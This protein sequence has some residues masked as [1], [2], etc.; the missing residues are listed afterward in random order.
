MY[1]RTGYSRGIITNLSDAPNILN[2]QTGETVF[3]LENNRVL[4]Y[5]G[6]LWMCDDFIKMTNNS[7][8]ACIACDLMGIATSGTL[9]AIKTTGTT[10]RTIGPAIYGAANGAFVA[11]AFKGIYKIKI[12]NVSSGPAN[13]IGWKVVASS[14]GNAGAGINNTAVVAGFIGWTMEPVPFTG[15][16]TPT[17]HGTFKCLMRGKVEYI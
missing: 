1:N 17:G 15:S 11:I 12:V 3:C 10:L 5:D 8:S 2:P 7:G 13:N 6:D 9:S 16:N 14:L 4:T